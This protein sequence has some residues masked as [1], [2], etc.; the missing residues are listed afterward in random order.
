M[1][2]QKHE[3]C[4]KNEVGWRNIRQEKTSQPQKCTFSE[5]QSEN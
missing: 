3:S 5:K 2:H 1:L 4:K